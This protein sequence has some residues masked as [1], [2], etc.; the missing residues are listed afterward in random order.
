M[1]IFISENNTA[2]IDK[3]EHISSGRNEKGE[4]WRNQKRTG[5]HI[6][7]W[8]IILRSEPVR[9]E[10]KDVIFELRKIKMLKIICM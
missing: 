9:M 4:Y 7:E 5:K 10:T 1:V 6:I 8:E 3:S 2:V